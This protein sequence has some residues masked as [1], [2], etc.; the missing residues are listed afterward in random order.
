MGKRSKKEVS[1]EQERTKDKA[2]KDDGVKDKAAKDD[3]VKIY[4]PGQIAS[5]EE[6]SDE[7][8]EILQG[9]EEE[10]TVGNDSDD[11]QDS[12]DQ[13]QE[14][15]KKK[16]KDAFKKGDALVLLDA[17]EADKLKQK[18]QKKQ[19]SSQ[20][21]VV[22]LGRIPHGFYEGQM[23]SYFSQFG[24][25]SRLR[26]SR[27]RKTGRSKHF[28]F[29]EFKD[30]AVARIVAETMDNYLLLNHMLQCKVVPNDQLHVDTFKG[31]DRKFKVI[32]TQKIQRLRQ[33]KVIFIIITDS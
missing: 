25:V 2:A 4:L 15:I 32:P 21:G 3:G 27:N 33:E 20:P 29:I 26:L 28:A 23:R 5:D 1:K 9:I 19:A 13:D 18:L 10:E 22:Y 8:R 17:T 31:A 11:G 30:A 7:E 12:S 16:K 24:E 14:P 6:M